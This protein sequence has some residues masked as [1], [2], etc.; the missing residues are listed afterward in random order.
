MVSI[1]QLELICGENSNPWV[2]R[3]IF[4][5]SLIMSSLIRECWYDLIHKW[6][7]KEALARAEE[8][9]DFDRSMT[10]SGWDIKQYCLFQMKKYDES[11]EILDRRLMFA[12]DDTYALTRKAMHLSQIGRHEESLKVCKRLIAVA[13][14]KPSKLFEWYGIMAWCLHSAGKYREAIE[15]YKKSLKAKPLRR[16]IKENAE[17]GIENCKEELCIT[18]IR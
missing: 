3:F 18:P 5:L 7:Y 16:Y 10:R 9:L 4:L 8:C 13:K 14:A 12:P 11:F 2:N 17:K 6:K 15:Y 1:N